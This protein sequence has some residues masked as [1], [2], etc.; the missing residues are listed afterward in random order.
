[1]GPSATPC[2]PEL[3]HSAPVLTDCFAHSLSQRQHQ[4]AVPRL[5]TPEV[6]AATVVP[7]RAPMG[8]SATPCMPELKHSAPMLTDCLAHGVSRH[9]PRATLPRLGTQAAG[10]RG[11]A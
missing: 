8:Q 10:S 3:K 1:M 6:L 4:A 7:H 2:M 9:Q 5:G 11:S